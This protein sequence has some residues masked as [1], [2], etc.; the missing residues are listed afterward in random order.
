M[1]FGGNSTLVWALQSSALEGTRSKYCSGAYGTIPILPQCFSFMAFEEGCSDNSL[2][3]RPFFT[4]WASWRGWSRRFT[5]WP[6]EEKHHPLI[7]LPPFVVQPTV[8]P[9]RH[10][11]PEEV[12]GEEGH[13]EGDE[14]H[15]LQAA[16][17][18]QVVHGPPQTQPTRDCGQRRDEQEAHHVA[19]QRPFFL[20]QARVTHPLH[21]W[22]VLPLY[23]ELVVAELTSAGARSREPVLQTAP[24]DGTQGP[25]T[26]TGGEQ[27]L[28]T[29]SVMTDP[30][31]GPLRQRAL[32]GVRSHDRWQQLPILGRHLH[33]VLRLSIGQT[34]L[35]FHC[36]SWEVRL[37]RVVQATHWIKVPVAQAAPCV[38]RVRTL[39]QHLR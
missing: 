23:S 17:K 25:C 16:G 9:E 21:Q 37:C 32:F 29:P 33:V 15:G 13:G 6:G 10:Q 5:M 38:G 1:T 31:H 27:L 34:T 19:E 18:V 22:P 14:A 20:A 24:V 4:R 12:D 2:F 7:G 8:I 30:T 36:F 39:W 35:L 11:G 28:L 3:G 26:L